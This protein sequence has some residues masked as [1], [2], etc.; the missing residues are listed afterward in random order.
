[1]NADAASKLG[2]DALP[3]S[4]AMSRMQKGSKRKAFRP[5]FHVCS[6]DVTFRLACLTVVPS[7]PTL[8]VT[9]L[10]E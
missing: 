3:L 10:P 2:A 5:F 7:L 9:P 1:V 6:H 4:G 8:S